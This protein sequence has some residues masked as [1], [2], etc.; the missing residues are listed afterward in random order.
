MQKLRL[1]D[2]AIDTTLVTIGYI[3]STEQL[4]FEVFWTGRCCKNLY[5]IPHCGRLRTFFPLGSSAFF[6]ASSRLWT[7]WLKICQALMAW[8]WLNGAMAARLG[9]PV[10]VFDSEESDEGPWPQPERWIWARNPR[11]HWNMI[12][13]L[14]YWCFMIPIMISTVSSKISNGWK[15][16]WYHPNM[17]GFR[18]HGVVSIWSKLMKQ[19]VL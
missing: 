6:V 9:C 12:Q 7:R 2:A 10:I 19:Q 17:V 18:Q 1:S 8:D 14:C 13:L 16:R 3:G 4:V 5:V 15:P 11:E